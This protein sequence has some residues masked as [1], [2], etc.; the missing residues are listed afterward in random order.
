MKKCVMILVLILLFPFV[1]AGS[2]DD[3]L[4]KV[5]YYAEEYEMGNIDYIQ[6]MVYTSSVRESLNEVLGVVSRDE[7][8]VLKE[9]QIRNALG[10]PTGYTKWVW[11]EKE[12]HEIKLDSEI[13][14]WE[15]I[16]FDGKKIR[17]KLNAFPSM[18]KKDGS[19]LLVYHLN[20]QVE[21]QKSSEQINVEDKIDEITILAQNFYDDS[22]KDNAEI[23]AKKSVDAEKSF[24]NYFRNSQENCEDLLKLIFGSENERAK[25]KILVQEINFFENE[26][27]DAN[28]RLE[29]CDD[30]EWN[31]IN[32]NMWVDS[33]GKFKEFNNEVKDFDFKK[34]NNLE[35][36]D[37]S[38]QALTL[39]EQIKIE[40][41]NKNYD[42]AMKFNNELQALNNAWNDKSNNVWEDVNSLFEIKRK[43][44]ENSP[45]VSREDWRNFEKEQKEYEVELRKN[46]YEVRKEFYLNLF[47]D[48]E[49][50][51]FYFEE[52]SF[53]KRLIELFVE[54]G[55]EICDNL[56]DDNNDG[57]LD[58]ADKQCSGKVCGTMNEEI[59]EGNESKS[60]ERNLYCIS[61]ICQLKEE[62]FEKK[63]AICGNNICENGEFELC[64]EDCL[65]CPVYDAISCQGKLV[66]SGEDSNGCLLPAI[67]IDEKETCNS[68]DDCVQPLCGASNCIKNDEG[69][70]RC[71]ITELTECKENVCNDGE[72]SIEKCFNGQELVTSIC[73]EGLWVSLNV[74]CS[75]SKENNCKDYCENDFVLDSS[76]DCS[77]NWKYSGL[78]P[79]CSCE[80]VCKEVVNDECVTKSDCGG[81]NDVCSNGECVTLPE[82]FEEESVEIVI[83]NNEGVDEEINDNEVEVIDEV[84]NEAD[85]INEKVNKE[86]TGIV[87]L[88]L[89][90]F[91]SLSGAITGNAVDEGGGEGVIVEESV[92]SEPSSESSSQETSNEE[93]IVEGINNEGDG[94]ISEENNK[95]CPDAGEPPE[96]NDNCRVEKKYD[97]GCHVG[98][99]VQ[100]GEFRDDKR[101]FNNE[102][103]EK[104]REEEKLRMER[105]KTCPGECKNICEEKLEGEMYDISR[106]V[107]DCLGSC[108]WKGT[109][110]FVDYFE[111]D[112]YRKQE[113]GVFTAGGQCR[114]S[115]QK[116]EGFIYFGGWGEPFENIQNLKQ[117][118]YSGGNADWCKWE[119]EN[120]LK[121]RKEIEKGLNQDFAIWFFEK[122]LTGSADDWESHMSGIYEIYWRNVDLQRQIVE[123][124]SCLGYKDIDEFMDYNLINLSYDTEYGHFEYWEEIKE[125]EIYGSEGKV[126]IISPYMKLWIFPPKEFIKAEMQKAM[127]EQ[128]FPGSSEEKAERNNEEGPTAEEREMIKQ[129]EKF[130]NDLIKISDKYGGN[131]GANVNFV[132][133]ET[134]ELVFNIYAQINKDD[135]IKMKPMLP[136]EA[137]E[138]DVRVKINFDLVYEMIETSEK[139]MRGVEIQSPPWDEKPRNVGVIK[140]VTNGVK[141]FF[142]IRKIINSAEYYPESAKKDAE[143]LF[144]SFF[145]MMISMG[146]DDE[147]RGNEGDL[148]EDKIDEENNEPW[149]EKESVTGESVRN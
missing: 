20:F 48:Y 22:S 49:K 106:C 8:G 84:V 120:L 137:S 47:K 17:I 13:A 62:E 108:I 139:E 145:K 70:G 69:I 4:S 142:K 40:L 19:K 96:V 114:K 138:E 141:M 30:C 38:G 39:I 6:L 28:I 101:E 73:S 60:I 125:T 80:W 14:F 54:R 100:C 136:E 118:Y 98:Y 37:F 117:K 1:V 23:L 130:M 55:E 78:Y 131:L 45:D 61:N 149:K 121:Q 77:G 115:L 134:G 104:F 123:R 26:E 9:E 44:L 50:K 32:L 52:V 16:I 68:N 35:L 63:E 92:E 102:F 64:S 12:K 113:L 51:E 31:W 10:E 83:E 122:Y 67:C 107:E 85:G 24:E 7:G 25:Q 66:V 132:D 15:K 94:E 88:I 128:Q 127:K 33:R 57:F 5:T 112:H 146:S 81:E 76:I 71:E 42:K 65:S 2:V 18:Y 135:I 124:M 29:I 56:E 3:E 95:V 119:L 91:N 72:K 59:I 97:D 133:P 140:E 103:D 105:E 129:N 75:E 36:E 116:T 109:K 86:V 74:E 53:E 110:E 82:I 126:R 147:K 143:K 41:Q 90:F 21:F 87:N 148:S 11:S 89:G 43:A 46:N 79:D 58:C 27:A 111:N 93:K 144:T 34:Y 99:D